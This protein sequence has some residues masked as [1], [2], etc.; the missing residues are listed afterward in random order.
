MNLQQKIDR[1]ATLV[2]NMRAILDKSETDKVPLTVEQNTAYD[3]M[4]TEVTSLSKEIA[5]A[6]ALAAT[7][8]SLRNQRDGSYRPEVTATATNGERRLIARPRPG[9]DTEGYTNA[10]DQYARVGRNGITPEHTNALQ[11]GADSEGGFLVPVEFETR[12]LEL[13][14]NLDPIRRLA[15]VITTASERNIPIE[16]SKGTF[17]YIGEE[18]DYGT[19]DPAIGRVVLGAWKSGGIIKVSEELLQDSFFDLTSYLLRLAG[20]R[21]NALESTGFAVG[22]GVA[23]PLGLFA[24]TSVGGTAITGITGG[25]SA[26]AAITAD[27]LVDTFHALARAYRQRATWITSDTM[28]KMIRKLKTGV[29]GDNTYIWQPGLTASQPD[30][31]LGRPVEVSDDATAPAVDAKSIIFGDI[32]HY[33]IADRLGTTVQR[34]NELYAATGQV[35]FKFS[36]RNDAK[37]TNAAAITFFTHGAAS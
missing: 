16:T 14:T 34:L 9:I 17:G 19:S 4:E 18:G 26:T 32:S 37:L 20:F 12:L 6:Q 29:S 33:Y 1:R 15:T 36:R 11:V 8:A 22:N 31:L 13:M 25:V 27:N 21:Y 5:R 23:K 2:K 3:Q 10:L 28:V 7:E 30:T 35:G 24:T